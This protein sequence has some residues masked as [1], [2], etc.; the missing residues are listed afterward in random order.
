MAKHN[1]SSEETASVNS[2]LNSIFYLFKKCYHAGI[3]SQHLLQVTSHKLIS[4]NMI[5]YLTKSI[6]LPKA[7][8]ESKMNKSL[9]KVRQN[10]LG[11]M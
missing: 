10:C 11:K 2:H 9:Q 5:K 7:S 1:D 3:T 6:F 8:F 4:R